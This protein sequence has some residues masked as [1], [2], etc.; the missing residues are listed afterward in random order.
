MT[1]KD[2]ISAYLASL[3]LRSAHGAISPRTLITYTQGI[4]TY[5]RTVGL[6]A[7]GSVETYIKFLKALDSVSP[8]S[9]R[10]YKAAVLDYYKFCKLEHG[11]EVDWISIKDA[12]TRYTK[13]P[14]ET[15][16]EF[17]EAAV[18]K[19]V[20]FS[21]TLT[22]SLEDLR[23]RAF[24]VTV[25]DTGL[26][27][28]EICA[29]RVCDVDFENKRAV[30]AGKGEKPA[31]IRFS[32]RSIQCLRDYLE[33]RA[34]LDQRQES[35]A[36]LLPLLARHDKSAGQKVLPVG[37]GGMWAAVKSVGSRAGVDID[38]VFPHVLR[39]KFVTETYRKTNNLVATQELSR[40][41]RIETTK[42]YTHLSNLELDSAYN[43]A[44]G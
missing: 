22:S 29:L 36:T 43:L 30:I 44:H 28:F 5:A 4:K 7:N 9:V 34:V 38:K 41:S 25:A 42:R 26:R 17:D 18:D 21:L 2:L 20:A 3:S 13:K 19:L 16:I 37:G 23:N 40:H 8:S 1:P 27:K 14:K 11:I 35:P 31:V 33:A 39:H 15:F 10:T 32:E 24:I 6:Q 12:T